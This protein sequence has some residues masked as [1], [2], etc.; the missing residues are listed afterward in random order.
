MTISLK[1]LPL[2]RPRRLAISARCGSWKGERELTMGFL[3][4][5]GSFRLLVRGQVGVKEMERLIKKLELATSS[6]L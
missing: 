3:S 1:P 5:D 4:K 2:I 6:M